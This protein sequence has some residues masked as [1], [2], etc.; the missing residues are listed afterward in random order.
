MRDDTNAPLKLKLQKKVLSLSHSSLKHDLVTLESV[1]SFFVLYL[2]D[3][4]ISCKS[5][6]FFKIRSWKLL[7]ERCWKWVLITVIAFTVPVVKQFLSAVH[8]W[9]ILSASVFVPVTVNAKLTTTSIFLYWISTF[10]H[11]ENITPLLMHFS[12]HIIP[13]LISF[14]RKILYMFLFIYHHL[15]ALITF[16]LLATSSQ[17]VGTFNVIYCTFSI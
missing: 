7:Q 17:D 2:C 12:V 11:F 13:I 16:K 5:F 6:G 4:C 10:E 14:G 3:E 15:T 1:T 8:N 9:K